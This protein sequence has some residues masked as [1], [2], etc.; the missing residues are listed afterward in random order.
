MAK[1]LDTASSQIRDAHIQEV[2]DRWWKTVPAPDVPDALTLRFQDVSLTH[3]HKARP[4]VEVWSP[5]DVQCAPTEPFQDVFQRFRVQVNKKYRHPFLPTVSFDALL[6]SGKLSFADSDKVSVAEVLPRLSEPNVVPYVRNDE[7][8]RRT[9]GDSPAYKIDV[10]KRTLPSWCTTPDHWI[11]PTPPPGFTEGKT[12]PAEE[13]YYIKIPTLLIPGNGRNILPTTTKP[14]IIARHFF[15][16]VHDIPPTSVLSLQQEDD[17]VSPA[18]KLIPGDLSLA[19]A[20]AFLGRAVQ[21]STEPLR[22]A[23]AE[24]AGKRRKVNTYAA[25]AIGIAWGLETDGDDK[26]TKLHCFTAHGRTHSDWVLHL[27]APLSKRGLSKFPPRSPMMVRE[28]WCEW[29][30]VATLP[31]D[32]RAAEEARAR[33]AVGGADEQGE[34]KDND[35]LSFDDWYEKT[36]TWIKMLNDENAVPIVEVSIFIT[37]LPAAHEPDQR[38]LGRI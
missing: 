37:V 13:Q 26:P 30:G 11:D 25:Q 4:L 22:P 15:L 3:A 20:R 9:Q 16:P 10:W 33:T 8:D 1:A 19:Q 28:Q 17:L 18:D 6:G 21:C 29:V 14:D 38:K 12:S 35:G 23:D 7:D 24:P 34:E 36:K 31:A 27:S 5:E 32:R 2:E